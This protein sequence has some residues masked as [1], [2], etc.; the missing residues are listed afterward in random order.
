MLTGTPLENRLEELMS[1][2]EF[3]VQR[4]AQTGEP[5]LRI[6]MPAPDVLDRALGS[7]AALLDQF[8]R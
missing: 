6:L 2:V 3:V 7:I 4:D 8:R 1:I 5:Y